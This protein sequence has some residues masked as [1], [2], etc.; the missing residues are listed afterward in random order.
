VI[1]KVRRGEKT[2]GEI[3]YRDHKGD[4]K[5]EKIVGW[6]PPSSDRRMMFIGFI[7]YA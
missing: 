4:R 6:A 1:V 7:Y 3:E 5:K 2:S